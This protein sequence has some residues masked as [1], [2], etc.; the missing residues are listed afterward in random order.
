M[1]ES[2][3]ATADGLVPTSAPSRS[4]QAALVD[5]LPPL[6][7]LPAAA[8]DAGRRLTRMTTT[9]CRSARA[10]L[11]TSVEG[12]HPLRVVPR[13]PTEVQLARLILVGAMTS[14]TTNPPA[15][16]G[17][18]PK[19][20]VDLSTL[21]KD[22]N[23]SLQSATSPASPPATGKSLVEKIPKTPTEE[24]SP[25]QLGDDDDDDEELEYTK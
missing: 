15:K 24:V 8:R 2:G 3:V 13:A 7:A 9:R 16:L 12:S 4:R 20:R 18:L 23:P 25:H 5:R 14:F 10:T 21:D 6:P 22:P 17:F 1:S 19:K 11:S